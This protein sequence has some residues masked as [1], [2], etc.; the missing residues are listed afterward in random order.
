MCH[1]CVVCLSHSFCASILHRIRDGVIQLRVDRSRI[2]VGRIHPVTIRNVSCKTTST[3]FL[4]AECSHT[5]QQYSA[6]EKHSAII[7]VRSVL[8]FAPQLVTFSLRSRLFCVDTF[9]RVFS[10]WLLYI[11]ER[12]NNTPKY[13]GLSTCS[14]FIPF[15]DTFSF[16]LAYLFLRWKAVSLVLVGF[17]HKRLLL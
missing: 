6:V 4:C 11:R 17:G 5:G 3:S 9:W 1:E 12:S 7:V 10:Q 13:T 16:T 14:S 2:G 8:A 15:H